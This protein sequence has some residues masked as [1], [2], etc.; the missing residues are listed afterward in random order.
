MI[1]KSEVVF[2]LILRMLTKV[3][4]ETFSQLYR[5]EYGIVLDYEVAAEKA[6][7]LLGLFTLL[8]AADN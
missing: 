7:Q 5:E 3:D 1:N 4:I 8:A 6:A 2:R